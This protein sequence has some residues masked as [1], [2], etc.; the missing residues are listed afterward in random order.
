MRF[1][2]LTVTVT[3]TDPLHKDGGINDVGVV[4]VFR[5]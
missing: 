3:S 1:K 2:A 5:P 4:L